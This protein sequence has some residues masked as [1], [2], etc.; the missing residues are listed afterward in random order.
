MS[1]TGAELIAAEEVSCDLSACTKRRGQNCVCGL[2]CSVCGYGEHMAIHGPAYGQSVGSKPVG[3]QFQSVN[4]RA[5]QTPNE[6][7]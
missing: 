7:E 4:E 2:P 1:D 6:R 3:H 5:K